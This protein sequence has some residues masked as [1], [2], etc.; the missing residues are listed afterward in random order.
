LALSSTLSLTFPV[1]VQLALLKP[2]F[3][4]RIPI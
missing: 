3:W 2:S 1:D 4:K